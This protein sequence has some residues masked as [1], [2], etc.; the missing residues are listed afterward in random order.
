[1]VEIW[2]SWGSGR[3][4]L[5]MEAV[6]RDMEISKYRKWA[7]LFGQFASEE[8]HRKVVDFFKEKIAELKNAVSELEAEVAQLEG[9]ADGSIYTNLAP[10]Y[11]RQQAA[12]KKKH[13]HG[14]QMALKRQEKL[15]S[16]VTDEIRK[17][18]W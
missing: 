8:S 10:K 16:I 18:T 14:A 9:M 12:L 13:L 7:K 17:W 4:H 3:M 2:F 15:Y 6:S 1:M 11:C 5:D